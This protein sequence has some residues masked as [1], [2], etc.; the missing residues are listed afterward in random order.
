MEASSSGGAEPPSAKSL[1]PSAA[2]AGEPAWSERAA[3]PACDT[4]TA[5]VI[6]GGFGIVNTGGVAGA[7]LLAPEDGAGSANVSQPST[8]QSDSKYVK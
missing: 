1:P 5:A 4:A 7:R 6:V 3:L 2:S 8:Q